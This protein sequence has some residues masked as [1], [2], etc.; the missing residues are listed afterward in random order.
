M[1]LTD[2]IAEKKELVLK[3][4]LIRFVIVGVSTV[5]LD[6][7]TLITLVENFHVDYLVSATFGFL[8]GSIVNYFL[9][10]RFVFQSGKYPNKIVEFTYFLVIT[11]IGLVLNY[12]TMYFF[13]EIIMLPYFISKGVS[14]FFVATTNF[15]MKKFLVFKG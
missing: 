7:L 10:V 15:I 8:A 11:L 12:F 2:N 1:E 9:S 5:T 6:Y 3:V 14:L 4:Q 13:T